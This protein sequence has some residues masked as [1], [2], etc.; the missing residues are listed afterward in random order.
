MRKHVE[1]ALRV[2]SILTLPFSVFLGLGALLSLYYHMRR[3]PLELLILA[4]FCLFTFLVVYYFYRIVTVQRRK[5]R[6]SNAEIRDYQ[7]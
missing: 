1:D 2:I 6:E 3:E 7:E 5:E 4:G